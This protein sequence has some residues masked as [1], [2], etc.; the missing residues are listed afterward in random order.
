MRLP[1]GRIQPAWQEPQ[2]PIL[3]V[4]DH[5]LRSGSGRLLTFSGPW[6]SRLMNSGPFNDWAEARDRS[7]FC[8]SFVL[9]NSRNS[10]QSVAPKDLAKHRSTWV[11][12]QNLNEFCTHGAHDVSKNCED[13]LKT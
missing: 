3:A 10:P 2:Y 12:L 7:H 9:V 5:P 11:P 8:H 4:S 13:L 6:L 1:V